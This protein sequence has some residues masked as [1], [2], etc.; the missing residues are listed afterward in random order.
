MTNGPEPIRI[1]RVRDIDGDRQGLRDALD[2]RESLQ[3]CDLLLSLEF[4]Q[5]ESLDV[6]ADSGSHSM[7]WAHQVEKASVQ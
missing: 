4:D 5:Q 7:C 3:Q 6:R 1:T 2:E